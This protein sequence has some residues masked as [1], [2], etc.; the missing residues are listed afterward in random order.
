MY[1]CMHLLAQG[2]LALFA[3]TCVNPHLSRSCSTIQ[4]RLAI[5][6]TREYARSIVVGCGS[7]I[8]EKLVELFDLVYGK[9]SVLFGIGMMISLCIQ[10]R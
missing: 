10:E 9:I 2:L 6:R 8:V 1:M 3:L 5:I 4:V 7:V